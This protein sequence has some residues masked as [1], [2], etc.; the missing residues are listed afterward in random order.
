MKKYWNVK[1]ELPNGD[2]K[3]ASI[4]GES[5]DKM[6]AAWGEDTKGWVGKIVS[7][8]LQEG[9]KGQYI[10]LEPAIG[11]TMAGEVPPLPTAPEGGREIQDSF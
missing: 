11:G 3:L 10:L 2:H 4:F 1:V 9:A 8:V 7:I 6:K 5:G